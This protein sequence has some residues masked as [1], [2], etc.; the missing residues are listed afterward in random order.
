MAILTVRDSSEGLPHA[1]SDL[2]LIRADGS[3]HNNL[4]VPV[5]DGACNHLQGME[6]PTLPLS[7][8]SGDIVNLRDTRGLM[9]LLVYPRTGTPGVPLPEGWNA[10]PGARGCTPEACGFRDQFSEFSVLPYLVSA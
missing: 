7:S 4:P 10:I 6:L 2:L 5:D 1:D 3:A 8:T 9:V